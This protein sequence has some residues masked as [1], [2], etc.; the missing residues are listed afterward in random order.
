VTGILGAIALILAFIGFGSLPLNV[1]GL[2]LIG[3]AVLLF[4]LETTVTSHGLLTVGGLVC[5]VLGAFTLYT[6]PGSP[7]AP[8]VS[9]AI[10]LIVA[11]AAV[12]AV[13]V[14]LVLV[15]VARVRRRSLAFAGAYGAGGTM[16][17]PAGTLGV[18]KTALGPIG[19]VYAAGEDWTAR[20]A[21]DTVIEPGQSVRVVG[22][23][24]LTLLVESGPAVAPDR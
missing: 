5:F 18:A 3:L 11:M 1:G 16:S 2:I 13:Y 6:A 21:G 12:T 20:V 22:Q 10:P 8:D 9:V 4:I 17:V 7:A 23:E 15:T 24:D 19:V 14:G